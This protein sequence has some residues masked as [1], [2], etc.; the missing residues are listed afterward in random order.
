MSKIKDYISAFRLRTLPLSLSGVLMGGVIAVYV[1]GV[2]NYP[3]FFMALLTTVLLQILSNIAN[4]YGDAVSGADKNRVGEQRMVASGKISAKSMK[5][6]IIVF[7]ILSFTSGVT[8]IY[9]S[10]I[11]QYHYKSL[12]LFIIGIIAI[13][14]AIKY[15]VGKNAYGYKGLGD[16]FVFIF[17]GLVS[18]VGTYFLITGNIKPFVFIPA[19]VIGLLS[20]AVLNLNNLRDIK[21]DKQSG[22]ITL[23]VK[24][25]KLWGKRYHV[26]II[27]LALILMVVYN[28]LYVIGYSTWLFLLVYP[29]FIGHISFVLNNSDSKLLDSQLKIIASSTF[30]LALF[31]SIGI[32]IN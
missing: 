6:M 32:L 17:F 18:V 16:I 26:V 2:Y 8:L 15:T 23:V 24:Y 11:L 21:T 12:S 5:Q 28:Y 4:D 30:T 22:K 9:V 20:V 27:S 13:V 29:I 19:S 14:A 3:V 1:N 10:P 31:Y 25:G 7:S